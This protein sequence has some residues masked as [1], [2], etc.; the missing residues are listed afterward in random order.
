MQMQSNR[1]FCRDGLSGFYAA[2]RK[3]LDAGKT[4]DT[5]VPTPGSLL[6]TQFP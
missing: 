5:R 6:I 3:T 2:S 1:W 4:R